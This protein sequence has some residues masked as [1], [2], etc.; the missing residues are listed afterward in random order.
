MKI[1]EQQ[2]SALLAKELSPT[3]HDL[4]GFAEACYNANSFDELNNFDTIKSDETDMSQWG[5]SASDWV[6][7]QKQ[8]LEQAM[9]ELKEQKD[10]EDLEHFVLDNDDAPDVEFTGWLIGSGSSRRG[11]PDASRWTVYRIYRTK[12]GT[13][14]AS[15]TGNTKWSGEGTRNKVKVCKT[16]A[17]VVELFNLSSAAKEALDEAGIKTSITVE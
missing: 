5:I 17:E 12:G 15:I 3:R 11:D 9:Y 1:N 4:K 8:A 2:Y 6:Y 13:L 7:A 16:E 14:I 10:W